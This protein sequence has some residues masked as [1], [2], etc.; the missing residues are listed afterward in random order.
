MIAIATYSSEQLLSLLHYE[1]LEFVQQSIGGSIRYESLLPVC[2][3]RSANLPDM[4]G[5][6]VP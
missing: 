1:D 6:M 5:F 3:Y 4:G 2:S